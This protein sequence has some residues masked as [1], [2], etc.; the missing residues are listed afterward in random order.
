[1]VKPN[2][3]I[4]YSCQLVTL[5]E[6][7]HGGIT[8]PFLDGAPQAIHGVQSVGMT[9]SFN[10]EQAF[11]LGQIEIYEN[12]EG[13]PDVEV[14][15]EKVIDGYPLMY[16]M[17]STGVTDTEASGLVARSKERCD[18]GLG[19]FGE[20]YDHVAAA[21]A[22]NGAA[23]VEV[24]CT[25]MYISSVGYTIPV[26]GNATESLTLVGNDKKWLAGSN[27]A[28]VNQTATLFDGLDDPL[29]LAA[30]RGNGPLPPAVAPASGGIQRREDVLME[31]AILPRS[32]QG[33]TNTG[34]FPFYGNGFNGNA[35]NPED[36]KP[37][38]HLQ[39]I[40]INTDFSRDDV[41]EL[42]R[43]TPYYRPANFPIEVTCDIE[44]I[45]TSGDFV[46]AAEEGDAALYHTAASGNNTFEE[47]IW[48]PLRCGIVFNL[49]KKNR[50]SSVTYGGGDATGGNATNTYSYSNFNDFDV[51]QV[52]HN[53]PTVM[54]ADPTNVNNFN[55]PF[56]LNGAPHYW[57]E[58]EP[59]SVGQDPNFLNDRLEGRY[60][61]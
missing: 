39:N 15:L 44:A 48:I 61:A 19:I 13:T 9:T 8:N 24:R 7:G 22:N 51:M 36:R 17:A 31:Y 10:L 26:D 58:I 4:L 32:I 59:A 56:G 23:Q 54:G 40:T 43:K 3:R 30:G 18:L 45:S 6:S 53:H 33:V 2:N 29:A 35:I 20:E 60:E 16:L 55:L 11:E 28:I 14:T 38:V 42:G 5:A 52:G 25:G 41:L 46:F 37:L 47:L 27:V 34:V 49:G 57:G 21:T 50:L 1:M 12:I